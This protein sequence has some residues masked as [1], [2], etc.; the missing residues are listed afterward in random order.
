MMSGQGTHE[1]R[2]A[3]TKPELKRLDAGSAE[4]TT[5]GNKN[6]A[7]ANPPNKS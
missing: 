2:T 4:S 6:D 5:T 7:G 3:W 1:K